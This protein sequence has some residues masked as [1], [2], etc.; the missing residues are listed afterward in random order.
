MLE[1]MSSWFSIFSILGELRMIYLQ[2]LIPFNSIDS[3]Y[4]GVL[5]L[6]IP[7]T[8]SQNQIILI[9]ISGEVAATL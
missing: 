1:K 5:D 7:D 4:N 9:Q 3:H 8:E 6:T 2:L